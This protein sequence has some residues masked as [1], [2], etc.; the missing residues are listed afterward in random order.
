ML[1]LMIVGF[2]CGAVLGMRFKVLVLVPAIFLGGIVAAGSNMAVG[3]TLW[4]SFLALVAVATA[5]Q[6]GYFFG[7]VV[8]HAL[9]APRSGVGRTV[10]ARATAL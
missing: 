10:R 2:L 7:S 8:R 4:T 6:L 5:L 3:E 1:P 9:A